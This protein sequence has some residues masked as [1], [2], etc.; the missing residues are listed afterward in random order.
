MGNNADAVDTGRLLA[1]NFHSWITGQTFHIRYL[2]SAL[3]DIMAHKEVWAD[4]GVRISHWYKK[5]T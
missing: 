2:Y 4:T 5:F 1:L 3:G